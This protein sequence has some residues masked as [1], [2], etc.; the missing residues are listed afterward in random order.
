[1]IQRAS[2]KPLNNPVAAA[3][4]NGGAIAAPLDFSR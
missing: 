1:M 2:G 4:T 3:I